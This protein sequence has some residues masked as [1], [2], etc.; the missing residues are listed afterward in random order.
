MVFLINTPLS[1]INLV[2]GLGCGVNYVRTESSLPYAQPL[3]VDELNKAAALIKGDFC[4][5]FCHSN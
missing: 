5:L 3:I 1:D 4:V 2:N